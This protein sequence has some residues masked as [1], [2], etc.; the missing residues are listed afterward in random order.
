VKVKVKVNTVSV[1]RPVMIL[2][3][4]LEFAC[5]LRREFLSVAKDTEAASARSSVNRT[6]VP[7]CSHWKMPNAMPLNLTWLFHS[8]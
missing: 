6:R 5:L 3:P 7:A 2:E 8:T 1:L 4:S